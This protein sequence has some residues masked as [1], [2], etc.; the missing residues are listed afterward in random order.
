VCEARTR[1]VLPPGVPR[2]PFGVRLTAVIA[3]LSGRYRLS[4]R[5]VRHPLQD[6]QQVPVS[7]GAVVRQEQA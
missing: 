1:A 5:E 2:C 7:L 6:L 3:L 4:R